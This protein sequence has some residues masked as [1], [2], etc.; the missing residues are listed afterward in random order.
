MV[1][2]SE[3]SNFRRA[4]L[5][6]LAAFVLV[7]ACQLPAGSPGAAAKSDSEW[8]VQV[9]PSAPR[10]A[11]ASA[12]N[13]PLAP[14]APAP[15]NA[16]ALVPGDPESTPAEFPAAQPMSGGSVTRFVDD[17]WTVTITP[18]VPKGAQ[19][20]GMR[21][22]EVYRS[23]PYQKAEYLANPGYRHEATLEVMFGQLRPK[24]VVSQYEPQTVPTPE[25]NLYW[26]YR[27]S[28]TELYWSWRPQLTPYSW[29][30]PLAPYYPAYPSYPLL[31]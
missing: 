1:R 17:D 14:P 3:L 16:V 9:R 22:E 11:A 15:A 6:T 30:Y 5:W 12:A 23:I 26:P 21:Y 25:F 28:Q 20:N 8:Q 2:S 13:A 4:F 31:Y 7:L 29:M 19:V 10:D 18:R 24:T 27:Y